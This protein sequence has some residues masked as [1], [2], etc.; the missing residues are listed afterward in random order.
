MPSALKKC[1]AAGLIICTNNLVAYSQFN[2][3]KFHIGVAASSFIYQGD[4]TPAKAGS[5]KTPALGATVFLSKPLTNAFSFRTNLALG[6]LKGD[7]A[8]YNHPQ[9]RQERA[10]RF[11]TPLVEIS[12]L[13]VWNV[14]GN[15]FST[16]QSK[17]APYIFGGI[18][19]SSVRIKTDYTRLNAAYFAGEPNV[20]TGLQE[21]EKKV[22]PRG[23]PAFPVGAGFS[24]AVSPKLSIFAEGAYRFTTTDYLDGVSKAANPSRNDY[25]S[26]YSIGI[27]YKPGKKSRLDCPDIKF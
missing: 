11:K 12:G 17:I 25:Y 6:Q 8:A 2:L 10:L 16:Y 9:W 20:L 5:F 13:V 18:G 4:L 15:N 22:K 21:D 24:V 23:L 27:V 26:S 14:L 1:I 3:Q 7:D 19:Y